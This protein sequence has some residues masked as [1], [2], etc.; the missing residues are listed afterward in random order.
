MSAARLQY[1]ATCAVDDGFA[2][3]MLTRMAELQPDQNAQGSL[4]RLLKTT[5]APRL[6]TTYPG[7][8]VNRAVLPSTWF[9]AL[10]DHY[11]HE[12]RMRLG[13]EKAKLRGFWQSF[14][15]RPANADV[16]A[17]RPIIGGMDLNSLQTAAPLAMHADAGPYSKTSACYVISV[18][19]L[20]GTGEGPT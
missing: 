8:L 1:L 7:E 4:V 13:A 5:G 11:P 18:A 15:S 3:P 16:M 17:N 10:H 19:S 14:G 2:H 20:V 9:R 6:I 12:F